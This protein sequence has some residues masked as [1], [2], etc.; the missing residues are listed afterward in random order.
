MDNQIQKEVKMEKCESVLKE[1]YLSSTWN[2]LKGVPKSSKLLLTLLLFLPAASK[3]EEER[4]TS[5]S[6]DRRF[7]HLTITNGGTISGDSGDGKGSGETRFLGAN[8][9]NRHPKY[10]HLEVRSCNL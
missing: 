4:E 7:P 6:E 2:P 3:G 9:E 10:K 5:Q 8:Q 1:G